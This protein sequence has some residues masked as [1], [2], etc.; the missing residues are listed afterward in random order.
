MNNSQLGFGVWRLFRIIR[1]IRIIRIIGP[2]N[3]VGHKQQWNFLKQALK[4]DRLGQAFIFSGEEKL[5]K[6]KIA[7][8]F[9]KMIFCENQEK[10]PCQSC[11]SCLLV[12]K[13][14]HPDFIF[15]APQKREIQINQ[16][17]DLQKA[18]SLKPV[19]SKAKLVVINDAHYLN[20]QAQNCILKTLEEPTG[21]TIFILVS[22]LPNVLLNT[23]QSRCESLKFFPLKVEEMQKIT[24]SQEILHHCLGRPGVAVSFLESQNNFLEFQNA[25]KTAK[26]FLTKDLLGKLLFI[27]GFFPKNKVDDDEKKETKNTKEECFLLLESMIWH[28]R[29][30]LWLRIDGE[31]NKSALLKTKKAIELTEEARVLLQTTNVNPK[32]LLEN[33]ILNF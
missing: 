6:K 13:A 30:A 10:A 33:L 17:R 9:V 20:T 32:L 7:F 31:V 12:E 23:I 25:L 21:Q 5:G 3:L 24:S 8:E 14:S 26:E 15:I 22:S 16:V 28:L 1:A 18:I 4:N 2:M 19:L 11:Q 29:K 27:K